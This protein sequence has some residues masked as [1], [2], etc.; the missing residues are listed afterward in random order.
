MLHGVAI[1]AD[2]I[3]SGVVLLHSDPG[4]LQRLFVIFP[5]RPKGFRRARR[6]DAFHPLRRGD[7][8]FPAGPISDRA[9]REWHAPGAVSVSRD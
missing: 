6:D 4:L 9:I 8:Y 1:A 5:C 3:L 2:N 7:L